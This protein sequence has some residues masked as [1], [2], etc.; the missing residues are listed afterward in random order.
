MKV[1][2]MEMILIKVVLKEMNMTLDYVPT[3]ES[4]EIEVISVNHLITAIIAKEALLSKAI[5]KH[6]FVRHIFRHKKIPTTSCISTGMDL[7]LS[8]IQDGA[9]F[10]EYSLWNFG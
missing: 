7:V 4:F 2:G 3:P 5:R 8:N 1:V 9:A 10:L 6:I